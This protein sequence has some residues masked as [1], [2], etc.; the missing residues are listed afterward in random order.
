MNP[1]L[2]AMNFMARSIS[3]NDRGLGKNIPT[4]LT[5][6]SV[7]NSALAIPYPDLQFWNCAASRHKGASRY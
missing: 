3:G 6:E 2:P 5:L 7:A 1:T 4:A